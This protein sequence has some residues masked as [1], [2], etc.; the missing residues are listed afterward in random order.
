MAHLIEGPDRLGPIHGIE[1]RFTTVVE[2][3]R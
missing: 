2:H 1:P 3:D